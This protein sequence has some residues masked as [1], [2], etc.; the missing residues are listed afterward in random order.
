MVYSATPRSSM[1]APLKFS[2][3][4]SSSSNVLKSCGVAQPGMLRGI[5]RAPSAATPLM[6]DVASRMKL[7]L[8]MTEAD[9]T[10]MLPTTFSA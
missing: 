10:S 7:L 5:M 1:S 3:Y 2:R 9:F 4:V 6:S 8:S